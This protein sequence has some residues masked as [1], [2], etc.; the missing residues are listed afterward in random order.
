MNPIANGFEIRNFRVQ[1]PDFFLEADDFG[2]DLHESVGLQ[3]PSGFGKTT[4][5][6]ALLGFVPFEGDVFL[7]GMELRRLPVH[8]RKIGV[9]FQDQSLFTHLNALENVMSGLL[10]QGRNKLEAQKIAQD[11]L[12]QFG[13]QDRMFASP[14]ELSGGERQRVA[15]LRATVWEPQMLILDEPFQ[16]LDESLRQQLRQAV[17]QILAE[18]PI[19]MIWIDH[20]SEFSGLQLRGE[21]HHDESGVEHRVFKRR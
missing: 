4:F 8:R 18:R 16:G 5:V 11:A 15:F 19:P 2:I 20:Q 3:A 10:L 6:R 21:V 13:L 7:Q 17:E 1:R 14:G 9:L 12:A